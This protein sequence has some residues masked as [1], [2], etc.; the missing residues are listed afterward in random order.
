VGQVLGGGLAHERDVAGQQPHRP[1]GLRGPQVD[2]ALDHDMD[3]ERRPAAEAHAPVPVRVGAR[4]GGTAGARAL[5]QI[6][7]D[8][9]D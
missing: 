2:L 9:H 7:Q 8:V 3:G 4:E 6:R 5:E 1:L